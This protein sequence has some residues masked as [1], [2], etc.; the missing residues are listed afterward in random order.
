[1]KPTGVTEIT[2]RTMSKLPF[3]VNLSD[4]LRGLKDEFGTPWGPSGWDSITW[5]ARVIA[6][7]ITT[8][9]VIL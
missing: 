7:T 3:Q 4:L 9:M 2:R 6:T 5:V 8:F 1:M